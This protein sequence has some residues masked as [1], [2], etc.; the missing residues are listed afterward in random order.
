MKVNNSI[1]KAQLTPF[2][3]AGRPMRAANLRLCT[4]GFLC[5]F[6]NLM[7]LQKRKSWIC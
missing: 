7:W 4:G 5:L 6:M 1:L 2:Y 3:I